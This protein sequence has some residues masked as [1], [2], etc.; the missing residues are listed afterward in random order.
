LGLH[1]AGAL[2]TLDYDCGLGTVALL[3]Q[4]VCDDP[5]L[6]VDGYLPVR[7]VAPSESR[8]QALAASPERTEW[9]L[10][11]LDRCLNLL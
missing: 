1:L 7:R 10:K 4:D 3:T 2:P 5:L 9:W 11:R 6:P 8:M